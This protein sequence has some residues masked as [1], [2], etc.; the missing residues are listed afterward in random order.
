MD[1]RG[2][3]RMRA[4]YIPDVGNPSNPPTRTRT[5]SLHRLLHPPTV[6]RDSLYDKHHSTPQL[7]NIVL[8]TCRALIER[9]RQGEYARQRGREREGETE[10][11]RDRVTETQRQTETERQSERERDRDRD[12][13]RE[14]QRARA[15]AH[16]RERERDTERERERERKKERESLRERLF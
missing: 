13:E 3:S 8:V 2:K 16:A 15:R 10:R 4:T 12:R 7:I 11:Q 6:S 5:C 1:A 14:R 9:G